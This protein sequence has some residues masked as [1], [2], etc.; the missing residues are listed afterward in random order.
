MNKHSNTVEFT[1]LTQQPTQPRTFIEGLPGHG[2]VAAISVD[3]ITKQLG[4][5][6]CGSLHSDLFPQVTSF[7][8]GEI[9]DSIRMYAGDSPSVLT[10]QSDVVLPPASYR[11]LGKC[12]R[13]EV[14]T[15]TERAVFLVGAPAESETEIGDIQGVTT[16]E[17]LKDELTAANIPLATDPGL[18]GGVTGALADD[19][20]HADIPTVILIV[21]TNPFYP[22]PLAA[23]S[24]IEN[25]V[26]PLVDFDI[27]TP[28]LEQQ[29]DAI[30][31]EL[32]QVAAQY[33]QFIQEEQT[34]SASELDRPLPSM[35]Q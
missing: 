8:E 21:K 3:Q 27:E 23:Q 1:Q 13:E 32:E 5:T 25:G 33:Q 12:L 16:T 11:P 15:N 34:G 14:M 17:A 26:E 35:Y 18:I 2:L 19:C 6:H 24:L 31:A 4:L 10:L 7:T 28:E 20:Y 22:D 9:Q 30:R 29:A